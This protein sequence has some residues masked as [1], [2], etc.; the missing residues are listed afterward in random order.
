MLSP[1]A[2]DQQL[3]CT[4]LELLTES[5]PEQVIWKAAFSPFQRAEIWLHR[6]LCCRCRAAYS[7]HRTYQAKLALRVAERRRVEA[8]GG[9][10]SHQAARELRAIATKQWPSLPEGKEEDTASSGCG[11]FPHELWDAF[12]R[13]CRTRPRP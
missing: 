7:V 11:C 12:L 3:V 5:G 10:L 1:E 8:T 6:Y 2:H 9:T 13:H 4:L